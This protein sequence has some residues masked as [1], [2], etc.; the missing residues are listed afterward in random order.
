MRDNGIKFFGTDGFKLDD[1]IEAAIEDQIDSF[2]DFPRLEG[3]DVGNIVRRHELAWEYAEHVKATGFRQHS[4]MKLVVDG[5]NGAASE[6]APRIFEELG[7]AGHRNELRS[8]TESNIN[9]DC[10]SL[11][12]EAMQAKVREIGADAGLSL[13]GDAD[14]V[15]LADEK[16]KWWM[17]ITSW[18]STR[19]T[20][21]GPEACLRTRSWER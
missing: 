21:P 20:A 13:D 15:I 11:H 5:A 6:M 9:C 17:A 14:R 8:P 19:F 2:E 4:G 1:A 12:P 3:A 16:G 7:R 10:G 18:R